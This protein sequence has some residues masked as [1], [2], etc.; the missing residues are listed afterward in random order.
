MRVRSGNN[1]NEQGFIFE[2]AC[3]N[4]Y[5]ADFLPSSAWPLK[6][7]PYE[8]AIGIKTPTERRG[9]RPETGGFDPGDLPE[10]RTHWHYGVKRP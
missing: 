6:D 7:G 8:S 3:S 1:R 9:Q 4:V 5:G 10:N 2:R